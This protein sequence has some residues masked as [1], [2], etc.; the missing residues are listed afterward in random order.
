MTGEVEPWSLPRRTRTGIRRV[1]GQGGGPE[2]LL[3]TGP[4]LVG[5]AL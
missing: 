5:A 1:A 4:D 3:T 2:A